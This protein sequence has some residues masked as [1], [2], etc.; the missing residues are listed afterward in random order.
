MT[1]ITDR[2]YKNESVMKTILIT[3]ANGFV[4]RNLRVTMEAAGTTKLLVCDINTPREDLFRYLAMADVVIHLAGVNR[5]KN[6]VEFKESNAGFTDTICCHLESLKRNPAILFASSVQAVQDNPYGRS[7]RQAEERLH[8]YAAYM[9]A[10]VSIFR[11]KN[12]FGKWCRPNYNSVVATFCYNV[13]HDLPLNISDPTKALELVYVDDV[14]KAI[15]MQAGKSGEEGGGAVAGEKATTVYVDVSPVYRVTL[16]DL[17]EHIRS[18]R[19]SRTTLELPDVGDG[20]IHALY[21]TYLS[22]LEPADF[23]YGLDV[24]TD[25]RGALAEFIRTR[26]LGQLFVSRTK[27]GIVRGNHYHHTKTE[28]FL[29]LEGKAVIRFRSVQGAEV[30]EKRVSGEQWQVVDIPPG[31]T[32]SIENIGVG[33][34]VTLFWASEPFDAT[35]PDTYMERV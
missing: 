10:S 20:F 12:I 25:K 8:Q 13:A 33:D 29:V 18:F 30:V 19:V 2:C 32:H 5:P 15:V 27:P 16:G 9:R 3:G 11:F 6:D 14:V 17:A 26:N 23:G 1:P 34:L 28:K 22:Y 4:G 7:K 35:K 31:Y 21:S 24:K